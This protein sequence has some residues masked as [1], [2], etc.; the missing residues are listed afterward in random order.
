MH[1]DGRMTKLEQRTVQ[2][3][4]FNDSVIVTSEGD[5]YSERAE[6]IPGDDTRILIR[7][8]WR[9]GEHHDPYALATAYGDITVPYAIVRNVFH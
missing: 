9:S 4:G 1:K 6:L 7:G 2:T 5:I 3:G 8:R